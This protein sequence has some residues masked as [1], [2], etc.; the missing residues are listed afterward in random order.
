MNFEDRERQKLEKKIAAMQAESQKLFEDIEDL[1]TAIA[2]DD[3]GCLTLAEA[4]ELVVQWMQQETKIDDTIGELIH[5]LESGQ[6][7]SDAL[8]GKEATLR[9]VSIACMPWYQPIDHLGNAIC[10]LISSEAEACKVLHDAGYREFE[11]DENDFF[12]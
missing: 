5:S 2:N 8:A 4:E 3:L 11:Y 6:F 9:V 10:D 1:E 12:D 7:L